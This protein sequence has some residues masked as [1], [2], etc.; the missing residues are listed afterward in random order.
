MVDAQ[1][2]GKPVNS[3]ITTALEGEGYSVYR[4]GWGDWTGP[5]LEAGKD[6]ATTV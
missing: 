6:A 1:M 2:Q 5:F 3:A 4:R